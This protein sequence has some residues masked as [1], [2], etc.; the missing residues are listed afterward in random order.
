MSTFTRQEIGEF[1][2]QQLRL[3]ASVVPRLMTHIDAALNRLT[4]ILANDPTKREYIMTPRSSTSSAITSGTVDMSS[5]ISSNGIVLEYLPMGRIYNGTSETTPLTF[6]R[7]VE[8]ART[9]NPV[10]NLFKRC[11]LEGTLLKTLGTDGNVLT[12]SLYFN[13]IAVP[14]LSNLN[15]KLDSELIDV[16]CG[17]EMEYQAKEA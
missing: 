15:S 8:A 2:R 5:L 17:I 4:D 1:A 14:T 10:G 12:G 13:C 7:N 6:C 9:S 16:V 11:W 3:P